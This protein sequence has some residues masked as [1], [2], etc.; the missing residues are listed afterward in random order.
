MTGI[1]DQAS[2]WVRAWVKVVMR[3]GKVPRQ[4]TYLGR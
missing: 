4:G 3:S 1:V 2:E